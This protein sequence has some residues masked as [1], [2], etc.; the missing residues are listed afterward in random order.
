[1]RAQHVAG[2][3]I[4][5]G[6]SDALVTLCREQPET[7]ADVVCRQWRAVGEFCF[8]AQFEAYALAVIREVGGLRH[9]PIEGIGLVH[10][11]HH[12]AVEHQLVAL[13]GITLENVAVEAVEGLDRYRTDE[14]HLPALRRIGVH[15]VEVGEVRRIPEVAEGRYAVAWRSPRGARRCNHRRQDRQDGKPH[16]ADTFLARSSSHHH[17]VGKPVE[18]SGSLAGRPKRSQRAVRSKSVNHMG[19]T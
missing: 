14:R 8:L 6:D 11:G 1:M 10:G 16:E 4:A 17:M 9:E 2:L 7:V 18:S 12:Q 13:H 19:T 15:I 3:D 5:D